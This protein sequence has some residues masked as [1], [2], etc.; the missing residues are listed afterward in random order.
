MMNNEYLEKEKPITSLKGLDNNSPG[1]RP[2]EKIRSEKWPFCQA[3][4]EMK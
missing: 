4:I 1:Q 3:K 2:G